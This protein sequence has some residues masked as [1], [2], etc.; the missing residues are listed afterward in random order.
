MN[1]GHLQEE[2]N[3]AEM[4]TRRRLSSKEKFSSRQWDDSKQEFWRMVGTMLEPP[5]TL[6]INVGCGY[7]SGFVKLE[8]LGH[9]VVN[10][11]MVYHML[12]TLQRDSGAKSCV[13]GDVNTLPFKKNAFDYVISIDLIHHESEGLFTL[14]ATF[15]DL[16]KPGGVLFLED[17]N[18]WGMF[19]MAK[20]IFLPR[21]AYRFMRSTYHWLKRSTHRPA[22]YEFPTSVWRVKAMLK[23]LGFQDIR[24]HPNEAYPCI[25]EW[26]F[27]AYGALGK[28]EYVRKHHNY[29]YMLS[30]TRQ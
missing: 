25:G 1:T 3:L 2:E 18:A 14:L 28:S 26:G 10:F 12:D 5:P 30:A 24:I 4:M 15:R 21:P 17:P 16:L 22:D 20:S 13:A 29:H 27:R 19:Q 11:D 6:A 23:R 8:Q 7:D 9:T